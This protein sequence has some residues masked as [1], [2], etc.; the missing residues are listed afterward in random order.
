MK[1]V[2]IIASASSFK[3]SMY[4][5]VDY[6]GS[7]RLRSFILGVMLMLFVAHILVAALV[8]MWKTYF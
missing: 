7:G 6:F 5:F 1:P 3:L 4:I 8:L 2:G